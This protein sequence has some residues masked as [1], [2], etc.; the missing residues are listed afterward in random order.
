MNPLWFRGRPHVTEGEA[1]ETP[2]M[3]ATV[4]TRGVSICGR[5]ARVGWV[6]RADTLRLAG[7]SDVGKNAHAVM[8]EAGPS[9]DD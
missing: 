8:P 3:E 4:G 7:F 2:G 6:V 1:S 5:M 9:D